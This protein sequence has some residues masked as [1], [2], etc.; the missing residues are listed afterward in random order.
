MLFRNG[1]G[2]GQADAEAALLF[3]ASGDI[4]PIEPFCS[5]M[6]D[7][8][9]S[10]LDSWYKGLPP[11]HRYPPLESILEW[12]SDI[13]TYCQLYNFLYDSGI[14]SMVEAFQAGVPIADIIA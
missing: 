6:L 5:K 10:M 12:A 9:P 4:C 7:P 3:L 1:P 2:D 8:T 13:S 14:D 11:E